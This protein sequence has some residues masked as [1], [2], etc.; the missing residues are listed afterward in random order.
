MRVGEDVPGELTNARLGCMLG[1]TDRVPVLVRV[2]D[3][4][5]RDLLRGTRE[6][7]AGTEDSSGNG[8]VKDF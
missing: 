2:T 3:P 4:R 7:G 6:G 1:P 5:L 8:A